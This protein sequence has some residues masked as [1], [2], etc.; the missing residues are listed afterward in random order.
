MKDEVSNCS[1][2]E[3]IVVLGNA[4]SPVT[5]EFIVTVICQGLIN[6]FIYY[7]IIFY[8]SIYSCMSK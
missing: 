7:Y 1:G 6:I 8:I 4:V 2:Y 5:V 3:A